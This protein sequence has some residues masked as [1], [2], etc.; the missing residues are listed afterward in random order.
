MPSDET[1]RFTSPATFDANKVIDEYIE[2]R[3]DYRSVYADELP[4]ANLSG[5]LRTA[6][7]L[8]PDRKHCIPTEVQQPG[9]P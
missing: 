6:Y 2:L 4:E 7:W 9:P 1:P 3:F 5:K 8:T